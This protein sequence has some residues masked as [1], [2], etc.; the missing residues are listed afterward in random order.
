MLYSK[1]STAPTLP[2]MESEAMA[3]SP[4]K[5]SGRT[6][7]PTC[8][9]APKEKQSRHPTIASSHLWAL[10]CDANQLG[11]SQGNGRR[12]AGASMV[13]EDRVRF[14]DWDV[15]KRITRS[16]TRL[17]TEG[18]ITP[19]PASMRP[20]LLAVDHAVRKALQAFQVY[21]FNEATA[22]SR[23]SPSVIDKGFDGDGLLQ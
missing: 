13:V 16:K 21:C 9:C 3:G 22:V 1:S 2:A 4:R 8:A 12:A 7:Y 6:V 10:S 14:G 19:L 15:P 17:N 23:G 18:S 20:R 11:V 5:R